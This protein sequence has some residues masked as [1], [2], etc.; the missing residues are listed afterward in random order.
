[1]STARGMLRVFNLI[2]L[3]NTQPPKK[4]STLAMQLEV[5]RS[6]IHRDLRL[7]E[8]LGYLVETDINHG[9]YLQFTLP[10]ESESILSAEELF[11]LQE[12]LQQTAVD[13]PQ[14]QSILYKFDHNLSMIPMA[15]ILPQLHIN[16]QI[17]IARKAIEKG[18]CVEILG[19]RSISSDEIRDR[20]VEPLEVT[21]DF[22]YLIGWDLEKDEQRQFKFARIN[23][24]KMTDR[25][26][27]GKRP[28]S[29]MD[30]FG[31]IGD[32]WLEVRLRLSNFAYHLLSEEYPKA[33]AYIR[34]TPEGAFY[35]G[36]VRNWQG[37]GRFVLGLP[38]EIEVL[39]PDE[40]KNYLIDRSS[41]FPFLKS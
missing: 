16:K 29:P 19:Y 23:Q 27:K 25:A 35:E 3:L 15:D 24:I 34:R 30:M 2:R 1:M 4:V 10:K 5:S 32:K 7:I 14:A 41:Q 39:Y 38:G 9:K 8:E 31:I 12:H 20:L 33:S 11:F 28:F 36:Q 40:F 21:A 18:I 6:Q 26:V 37:I 22:R 13:S 17:Q